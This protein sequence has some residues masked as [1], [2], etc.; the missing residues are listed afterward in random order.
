MFGVS[1][2]GIF[3]MTVHFFVKELKIIKKAGS[4]LVVCD[5]LGITAAIRKN[6]QMRIC[7]IETPFPSGRLRDQNDPDPAAYLPSPLYSD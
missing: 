2:C 6:R 5:R 1:V 7:F 4:L 3:S